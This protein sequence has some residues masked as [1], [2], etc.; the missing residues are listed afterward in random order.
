MEDHGIDAI[1]KIPKDLTQSAGPNYSVSFLRL[2]VELY[3]QYPLCGLDTLLGSEAFGLL[4]SRVK[5]TQI[6]WE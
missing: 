5:L 2:R 3:R 1:L 4:P 6:E